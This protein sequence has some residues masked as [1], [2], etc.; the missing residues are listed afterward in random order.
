MC[1]NRVGKIIAR[2]ETTSVEIIFHDSSMHKPI[3]FTDRNSYVIADLC[4]EAAVFANQ[5][6]GEISSQIHFFPISTWG[7]KNSAWTY[8]LPESEN[9][10]GLAIS[11]KF[12]ALSTSQQLVRVFLASGMQYHLFSLPGPV[13]TLCLQGN[14]L[15]VVY[16]QGTPIGESQNLAF[17]IVDLTFPPKRIFQDQLPLSASS[18]LS[19]VGFSTTQTLFTCDSFGVLRMFA[20]ASPQ[21]SQWIPVSVSASKFWVFGVAETKI[22]CVVL[23]NENYPTINPSPIPDQLEMHAPLL[24]LD[25]E[26]VQL[27]DQFLVQRNIA[28]QKQQYT[29]DSDVSFRNEKIG[30]DTLLIQMIDVRLRDNIKSFTDRNER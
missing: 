25:R 24:H 1:F 19:W 27:E 26:S 17:Q 21:S 7:G 29:P 18:T 16:H 8:Q 13:V 5:S 10:I 12:V 14:K 20:G 28:S 22:N 6:E 15:A 2:K 23:G 3:K 9:A 11:D 30:L 4:D